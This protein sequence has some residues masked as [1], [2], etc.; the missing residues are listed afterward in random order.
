LSAEIKR[1]GQNIWKEQAWAR[2]FWWP[3]MDHSKVGK[4]WS[5]QQRS[6][7]SRMSLPILRQVPL[8]VMWAFITG[9]FIGV[10]Q[11]ITLV[12]DLDA[13]LSREENSSSI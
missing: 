11:G 9:I 5:W 1:R 8:E 13:D 12:T 10:F 7:K 6:P 4:R 2:H 3:L